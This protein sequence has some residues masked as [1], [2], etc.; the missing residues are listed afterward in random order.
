MV[1]VTLDYIEKTEQK[2]NTII[3]S[4]DWPD[5]GTKVPIRASYPNHHYTFN[6]QFCISLLV[7]S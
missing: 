2:V 7:F 5:N 4:K 1:K 3:L 6:L